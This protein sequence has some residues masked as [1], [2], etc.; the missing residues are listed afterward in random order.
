VVLGTAGGQIQADIDRLMTSRVGGVLVEYQPNAI[1]NQEVPFVA[2]ASF[3]MLEYMEGKKE[4]RT[5]NTRYNQG[6]DADSLNKTARGISMIQSAAQQKIDLIARIFAETGIKDLFRGI[7]YFLS[8]Y[9]TKE[10]TMRL[11]GKWVDIDPRQWKDQFDM[12]VNVGLGTGNKDAQ[13]V[14]LAKMN[15]VQMSLMKE[16]R[17]YMVTDQNVFNL[18]KKMAENMGFKHPELFITDP[19]NAQKPPPQP[20]PDMLKLQ[21]A[22]KEIQMKIQSN[23]KIRQFDAQ[24]KKE[25][26]QI[27]AQAMLAASQ[28]QADKDKAIAHAQ[29]QADYQLAV[30]KHNTQLQGEQD[31]L[32]QERLSFEVDK[33]LHDI[34]K[35][36]HS[37]QAGVAINPNE[38]MKAEIQADTELKKATLQSA[39][40]IEI[41]T[42]SATKNVQ[43]AT[44][45]NQA[46]GMQAAD[47]A[48][49][50]AQVL[51]RQN[52]LLVQIATPKTAT[53]TI[54]K[55]ADGSHTI[56][57]TRQ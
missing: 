35:Q 25:L 10:M 32:K 56:E 48:K 30:H 42:L 43:T 16:G 6:T 26:E 2:G 17:G 21:Q 54:K 23:E 49:I 8:K 38:Q 22:D 53:H 34:Q 5:G 12:T 57:T 37:A 41:A 40:Q 55:G 4:Q 44:A 3:P 36:V 31:A 52:E 50:M 33:S 46:A 14:H 13:L 28:I 39:T 24:T 29:I 20:N 15:E 9:S 27:K 47:T 7:A 51:D 45:T 11:R 18:S 19:A 1:R